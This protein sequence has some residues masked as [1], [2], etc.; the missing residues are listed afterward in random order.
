ML[1]LTAVFLLIN[2]TATRYSYLG[3][4]DIRALVCSI[5]L[6]HILGDADITVLALTEVFQL[7][8]I[9]NQA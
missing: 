9:F 3:I 4:A 8:G 6:G 5:A 2:S 7:A 1:A